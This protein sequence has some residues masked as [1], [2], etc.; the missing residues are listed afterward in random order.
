MSL[1]SITSASAWFFRATTAA[2]MAAAPEPMIR[3]ST[4][5][6]HAAIAFAILV[7]QSLQPADP[8][9]TEWVPARG[10]S[11]REKPQRKIPNDGANLPICP[12][13]MAGGAIGEGHRRSQ[14]RSRPRIG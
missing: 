1:F 10:Q 2:V 7:P 12:G 4:S 5:A 9:Y 6:S 13:E 11:Y 8:L 3:T 14:G